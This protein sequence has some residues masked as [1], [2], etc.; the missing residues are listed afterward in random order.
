MQ[1]PRPAVH[2]SPETER[3]DGGQHRGDHAK[4]EIGDADA[5][6]CFI[7]ERQDL[8]PHSRSEEVAQKLKFSFRSITY[9]PF[10]SLAIGMTG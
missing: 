1:S 4:D 3:S 9:S 2:K 7:V 8:N 5:S 6:D 10:M